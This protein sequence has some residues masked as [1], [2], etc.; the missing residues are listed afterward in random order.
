MPVAAMSRSGATRRSE[1]ALNA[2]LSGVDLIKMLRVS[3][4]VSMLISVGKS[5]KP[6]L[7][8]KLKEFMSEERKQLELG[9]RGT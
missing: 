3:N 4:I 2:G 9:S 5:S 7:E 6:V 8:G 1:F